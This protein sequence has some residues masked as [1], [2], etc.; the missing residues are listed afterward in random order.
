[1]KTEEDSIQSRSRSSASATSTGVSVSIVERDPQTSQFLSDWIRSA[2]GFS[3]LSYH[4]TVETALASLPDEKPAIVLIDIGLPGL[5]TLHCIRELKPALPQIQFVVLVDNQDTEPIFNALAAGASGYVMKQIARAELLEA[6]RHI[7]AGGSPI[8]RE[9]AQRVLRFFHHSSSPPAHAGAEL[10]PREN[11]LLRL[12]AA[13]SSREQAAGSLNMD[14]PMVSTYIRSIYEKLHVQA[15]GA[16][17][18]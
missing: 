4:S 3:L 9:I 14:L 10:S 17:L 15:A 1:M 11:R 8:N 2:E 16:M 18:R 5:S 7:H 12:L 6:L 13:G